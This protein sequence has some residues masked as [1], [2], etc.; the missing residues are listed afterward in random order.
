MF[1]I[2][3]ETHKHLLHPIATAFLFGWS[4]ALLKVQLFMK[5]YSYAV[6]TGEHGAIS[7]NTKHKHKNPQSITIKQETQESKND[8][9]SPTLPLD[10]FGIN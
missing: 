7:L 4:C 8:R 5:T 9:N 2:I 10:G 6:V 3:F 1:I